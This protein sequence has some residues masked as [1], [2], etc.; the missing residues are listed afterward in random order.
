MSIHW[1]KPVLLCEVAFTEWTEDGRIRHPSFQGLREDK[2]AADVKQEKPMPVKSVPASR[3]IRKPGRE[4][5]SCWRA[6]RS[7]IPTGS[8]PR[9]AISRRANWPNTTPPSRPS[10][11][12]ASLRHPLSLLRCP[13]G[14]GKQCFFQRNPGR[15]LGEDV[16]PFEF[17]HKGKSYEYLYIEDEKGLLEIIQMGAIEIHP[18]GAPRRCHRLSRP[19]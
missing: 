14:I 19:R 11:C 17:R 2:E 13:S 4:A 1:V 18:W 9:Q 5:A 10:C 12:R 15:G 3:A 16:K 8:F 6:S 7:R